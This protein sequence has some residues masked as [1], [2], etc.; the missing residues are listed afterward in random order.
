MTNGGSSLR[1]FTSKAD[2]FNAFPRSGV[3]FAGDDAL[4][5]RT[6]A[7]GFFIRPLL[8]FRC[9]GHGWRASPSFS[10][11]PDQWR[12]YKIESEQDSRPCSTIE[13][14]TNVVHSVAIPVSSDEGEFGGDC[15][16]RKPIDFS[17]S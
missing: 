11:F 2:I 9:R 12:C 7:S 14:F 4:L 8:R 1:Q 16:A 15:K 3:W 10:G 17:L 13:L 5:G 6:W